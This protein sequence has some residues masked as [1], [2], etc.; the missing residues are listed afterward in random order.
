MAPPTNS[1]QIPL[2]S[3]LII[4][5][6]EATSS[7]GKQFARE[8]PA[9]RRQ[10]VTLAEEADTNDMRSA[11]AAAR[12]A[13]DSNSDNWDNNYKLRESPVHGPVISKSQEASIQEYVKFGID[14][15]YDLAL[16]GNALRDGELEHGYYLEPTIF[17]NVDNSSRLGQEE[18]FGP[19]VVVTSF[20]DEEEAVQLA[21]DVPY[22]LV[23]GVWSGDYVRCMRVAR[24]LKAGTVWIWDDYA[25]PVEGIWGGYK[26]S[27]IGRELGPY[28]LDDFVE[29]NQIFTDGTGLAMKPAYRH[30]IRE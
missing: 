7:S 10:T 18:I 1:V 23:A 15:G 22:G 6:E 13:L 12:H 19:V 21:N 17:D 14:A 28:G 11:I 2:Q 24:R 30:V 25:Q 20:E 16:G 29:V 4:N 26:E 9:D 8:N 5:G 27:G 3:K